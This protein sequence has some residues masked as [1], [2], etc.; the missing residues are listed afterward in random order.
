MQRQSRGSRRH[1]GLTALDAPEL[2]FGLVGAVGCDLEAVARALADA[3]AAANYKSHV[4]R[5]SSLL[6]QLDK[7]QHLSG[8]SSGSEYERISAHMSAGTELRKIS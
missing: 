3:L 6:H 8:L 2:V 7:Y 1:D 4:I 5:V